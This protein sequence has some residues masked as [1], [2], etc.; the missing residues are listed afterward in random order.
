MTFDIGTTTTAIV[1][2]LTS[3]VPRGPGDREGADHDGGEKDE[4]GNEAEKQHSKSACPAQDEE[5][6]GREAY[7]D[8][9]G[10]AERD[11]VPKPGP[12]SP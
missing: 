7:A 9:L 12:R 8:Y 3:N 4:P 5:P 1:I 2:K 6:E 10:T 11:P